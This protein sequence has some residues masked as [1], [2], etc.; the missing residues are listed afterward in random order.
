MRPRV[1]LA[2]RW[3]SLIL[4]T[5]ILLVPGVGRST[6]QLRIPNPILVLD[7]IEHATVEGKSIVRYKYS[8]WNADQFPNEMFA[9]AP[10]LPPCGTNKNSA[11]TWVSIKDQSGKRY[12][13]FCTLKNNGE[14][15]QVWFV[16]PADA[17]PPSYVYLE[18]HDRKTD[19]KYKSNLADTTL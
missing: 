3:L 4:L 7:K 11:R 5:T 16:L 18:I 15:E 10:D 2:P 17:M 14:L 13:E 6:N 12:N 19:S 8:V 9:T 1:Y